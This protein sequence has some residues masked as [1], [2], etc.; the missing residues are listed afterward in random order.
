MNKTLAKL[1]NT[2]LLKG[3]SKQTGTLV[4]FISK[5]SPAILTG[6]A[7]ICTFTAVGLAIYATRE[8]DDDLHEEKRK[9]LE[10]LVVT[11][12][13]EGVTDEEKEEMID[14]VPLTKPEVVKAVW[15]HYIPTGIALVGATACCIGA[16]GINAK[17]TAAMAAL[18]TMSEE[19]L[20][21]YKEK[22]VEVVGK[23]KADKISDEVAAAK[24]PA[25]LTSDSGGFVLTEHGNMSCFE[26][27]T[28]TPFK[29][30][31]NYIK[32]VV[33]ELNARMI[34]GEWISLNEF[35]YELKLPGSSIGDDI[36]WNVDHMIDIRYTSSLMSDCTPVL[37]ITHENRP[38][39]LYRDC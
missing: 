22:T 8:I 14:E 2:K 11:N 1:T 9:H 18:Y 29:S 39:T 15:K 6:G 24:V 10:R 36:G 33:N 5:N 30:D 19:A 7:V 3:V 27:I 31:V 12:G 26:P 23:G 21:E 28:A 20:K 16:Q 4:R 32:Q 34:G 35:L 13:D 17:R 37:V 38:F 25:G